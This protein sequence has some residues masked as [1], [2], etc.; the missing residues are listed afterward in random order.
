M[1]W[2]EQYQT[3]SFRGAAFRTEFHERTGGRRV[4]LHEYPGRDVPT[5]ED[6]GRLARQFTID[7]HIIGRDYTAAR[8]ALIDALESAGP[9]L[10]VHPWHGR[11]NVVVLNYSSSESTDEGGIVRLSI[12]FAEAGVPVPAPIQADGPAQAAMVADNVEAALP[13]QFAD[14]F[15]VSG[16]AD[17]VE[18]AASDLLRYT[19]QATRTLTAL[20]GGIGPALRAF[21]TG[22][23]FLPDDVAAF[24]RDPIR[25]AQAVNRMVQVASAVQ[26]S[27][28]SRAGSLFAMTQVGDDLKPVIGDTPSRDLERSNRRAILNL[29]RLSSA[30][31]LVRSAARIE[32]AS[33]DDAVAL[34]DLYSARL[35]ILAVEAADLGEDIAAAHYDDLRR[36]MVR[37]I[38][39]RGGSLVRLHDLPL[40]RTEPALVIANRLYGAGDVEARAAALTARNNVRHPGFVTGGRNLQV[41]TVN[42]G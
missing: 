6:L 24:L 19:A 13:Q 31:Q 5:A 26:R 1:S 41:E 8:D 38:T 17:F 16:A 3:G 11:R 23:S 36:V 42:G 21:E 10:L 25:L 32:F 35:D 28:R 15:D 34:R 29:Y 27:V 33:Y 37:A 14:N 40:R 39:L 18:T 9:G 2:R 12:T 7:C 20:S 22:L 30:A 4:A